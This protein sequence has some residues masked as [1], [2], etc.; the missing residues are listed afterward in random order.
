LDDDRDKR[1]RRSRLPLLARRH[2]ERKDTPITAFT[3]DCLNE[4]YDLRYPNVSIYYGK[5]DE[6][7]EQWMALAET[8]LK[9]LWKSFPDEWAKIE[10]L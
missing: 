10:Y 1:R 7:L 4:D 6:D 9:R 3:Y 2:T 5:E 8:K